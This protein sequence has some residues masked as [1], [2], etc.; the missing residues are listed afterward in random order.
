MELSKMKFNSRSLSTFV[1]TIMLVLLP[2]M[3]SHANEDAG[4]DV[5]GTMSARDLLPVDLITNEHFTV[6]EEVTWFD[7]LNQFTVDTEYGSFEIWG[8]P[9]LRVRLREFIAWK[10]LNETS[11]LEAGAEGVGRNALR[12]VTALLDAFAHPITTIQGVPQGISRLFKQV[13]RD[14]ENIAE[15]VTGEKH[16][17]SP[18]SLNRRGGDKASVATEAAERLV[19][20]N[21]AY[22]IWAHEVGVNPYSTNPAIRE[23]LNRV[24]KIDAY[25]GRG[26]RLL[27]PDFIKGDLKTVAKVSRQIYKDDWHEVVDINK[28]SLRV[29]GVDDDLIDGFLNH[30]FINLSLSTLMVETLNALD[31]VEGRHFVIDQAILLET[32]AEAI[33]FAESLLMAQWFH[34]NEASIEK[35]L[36]DTLVPVALTQDGRVI[37]FSAADL[38]LWTEHDA[39]VSAGFTENYRKYSDKREAWIA[40]LAS[41]R[42]IEGLAGLGWT[43]RSGL[44]SS[45]LPEIPWGLQDDGK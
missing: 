10:I 43:V 9:M 38:A 19:G 28:K 40:D 3:S 13:G 31:G 37:V 2:G 17:E 23:E 34:E 29:M 5:P 27:V 14:L 24:A 4:F 25:L 35:M 41:P 33:W 15:V 30:D 32:E 39:E 42:F 36:F 1:T 7:G 6:R 22:R 18:G 16:G 45:V 21:K 8:E 11:G 26:T 44:R 20:V 12:S